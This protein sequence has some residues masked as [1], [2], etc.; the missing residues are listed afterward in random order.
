M[1]GLVLAIAWRNVARNW[2]RSIITA[3]A[4]AMGLT[5]LLFLWGFND[6]GHN[7]MTRNF[8]DAFVGSLQVHRDGYFRRPQLETHIEDAAPILAALE[9]AGVER[10]SRRLSSFVLAADGTVA[11][12]ITTAV[13]RSRSRDSRDFNGT[14]EYG[15]SR[16]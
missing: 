2:R 13:N 4:F 3:A 7:G 6:G 8:Q 10:W 16:T 14:A 11:S 15:A 1:S 5:A 9:G 12:G